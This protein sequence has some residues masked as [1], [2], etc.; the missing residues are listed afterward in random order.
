MSELTQIP[1]PLRHAARAALVLGL[2]MCVRFMTYMYILSM[3]MLSL[4]YLALTVAVPVVAFR[5]TRTYRTLF[6]ERIGF[7]TAVAWSHGT[8]LFFFASILLLIPYYIYYTSVLPS[9]IPVL[10]TQLNEIYRTTPEMRSLLESSFGGSPV[11]M[12]KTFLATNSIGR[13]LWSDFGMN[14]FFGSIIALIN[15]FIL[16]RKPIAQA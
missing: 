7:P 15:A 3:P 5:L 6:P 16:R 10:E 14:L 11:E 4:V 9:Q 1:S 8:M 2:F 13:L 12:L